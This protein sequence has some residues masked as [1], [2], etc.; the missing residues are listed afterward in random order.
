MYTEQMHIILIF[1][2]NNDAEGFLRYD[3][4]FYIQNCKY[5]Y[6]HLI[7][8]IDDKK[9]K[10]EICWTQYIKR[11]Y[12]DKNEDLAYQTESYKL[13]KSIEDRITYNIG[14]EL[15]DFLKKVKFHIE[16]EYTT[17]VGIRIII[18]NRFTDLRYHLKPTLHWIKLFYYVLSIGMIFYTL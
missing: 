17:I 2:R 9:L 4:Q 10:L 14:V 12:K 8:L 18:K 5:D 3:F 7:Q 1:A 11:F 16:L 15:I 13:G 6:L